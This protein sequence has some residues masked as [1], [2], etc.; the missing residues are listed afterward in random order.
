LTERL[1]SSRHAEEG[2]KCRE[3]SFL[4]L[5]NMLACEDDHPRS[6]GG[7]V[8]VFSDISMREKVPIDLLNNRF[9]CKTSEQC[10]ERIMSSYRGH[11]NNEKGMTF[12]GCCITFG[13]NGE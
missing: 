1:T 13:E 5:V 10:A 8:V 2:K 12:A 7:D 4:Q 11:K 3:E 6:E 9:E